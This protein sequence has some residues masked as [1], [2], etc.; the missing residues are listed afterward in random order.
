LNRLAHL[1]YDKGLRI[2]IEEQAK[3]KYESRI[4]HLVNFNNELMKELEQ[5][6]DS[7]TPEESHWKRD[8]L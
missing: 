1:V 8:M 7:L 3:S 5:Y 6:D 4:K 2:K